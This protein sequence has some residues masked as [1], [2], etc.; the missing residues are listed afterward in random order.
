LRSFDIGLVGRV[1][2]KSASFPVYTGKLR[3][4]RVKWILGI[5]PNWI[6]SIRENQSA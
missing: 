2:N 4:K 3:G 5:T 1:A 6:G